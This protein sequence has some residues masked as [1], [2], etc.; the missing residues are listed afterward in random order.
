MAK[1]KKQL[2]SLADLKEE[3]NQGKPGPKKNIL[4]AIAAHGTD[5]A[6]EFIFNCIRRQWARSASQSVVDVLPLVGDAGA[7]YLAEC[8]VRDW[9]SNNTAIVA[10]LADMG[11]VGA[12]TAKR[13]MLE[14][15]ISFQGYVAGM[16]QQLAECV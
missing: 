11:E 7:P 5:E 10:M 6:A 8:V 1:P 4:K 2:K 16:D 3:W 12:R 14:L 9:G 15:A 13:V